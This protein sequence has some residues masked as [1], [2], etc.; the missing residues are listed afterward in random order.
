MRLI[1]Y[2]IAVAAVYLGGAQGGGL[3]TFVRGPVRQRR[4]DK[5]GHTPQRQVGNGPRIQSPQWQKTEGRRQRPR[6]PMGQ[7]MT[8]FQNR[9]PLILGGLVYCLPLNVKENWIRIG[10]TKLTRALMMSGPTR[11]KGEFLRFIRHLVHK[12]D[13][14]GT[15]TF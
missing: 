2:L 14:A 4:I 6:R 7:A 12:K 10:L 3:K 15:V 11:I 5:G 13:P 9:G 1:F 8:L